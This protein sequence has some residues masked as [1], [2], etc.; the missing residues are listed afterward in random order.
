MKTP[1]LAVAIA[2]AF[3]VGFFCGHR[4]LF[5]QRYVAFVMPVCHGDEFTGVEFKS[6]DGQTVTFVALPNKESRL[7]TS[8]PPP[9]R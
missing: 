1:A 8:S 9:A 3:T 5:E 2:L 4:H 6:N 7:P